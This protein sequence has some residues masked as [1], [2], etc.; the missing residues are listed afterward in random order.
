MD[1][2]SKHDRQALKRIVALLFAFATLAELA[3]AKPRPLRAAVLWLLRAAEAIGRDFV[4]AMV[5]NRGGPVVPPAQL[6]SPDEAD[7]AIRLAQSF[8]ALAELL[9]GLMRCALAPLPSGRTSH[10]PTQDLMLNLKNLAADHPALA[11][12]T[13]EPLY[14]DTS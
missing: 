11:H 1:W 14:V 10:R 5:E 9:G 3:G 8:R 12:S 4:S 6:L 7:D 13:L 2:N